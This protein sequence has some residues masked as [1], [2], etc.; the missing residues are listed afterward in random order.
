MRLARP[1]SLLWFVAVPVVT[2]SLWLR[3]P[4]IPLQTLTLLLLSFGLA[5]AGL[6]TLNDISDRS[7]DRAS[8]ESQRHMRPLAT[9]SVS[10]RGAYVQVVLLETCALIA[11]LAVSPIFLA[12]VGLG[13]LYGVGYSVRP[14]YA[15]GR[16]VVSQA[17]WIAVWPAM[18]I[19]VYIGV[20]G[21]FVAGLPYLAAT[22]LFMGVGET[23]AKDLRDIDNDSLT[24]KRTTPVA[25]GVET[26]SAVSAVALVLGSVAYVVA[27]ATAHRGAP[28]LLASITV[29]VGL[30]CGRALK[31][32]RMLR[33][34]YA[35]AD[36]RALHM[37]CI[38]VF[39]T[40]NLLFI[41]GLGAK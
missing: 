21:D 39:L 2:I 31:L 20:G 16:P 27:A 14:V 37:G 11:A 36:A 24:G 15:E 26:A 4:A 38:R 19:G 12:L 18:Y 28:A 5:D 7:T 35:K 6:T 40:A 8:V 32:T 41:T 3:G 29:V 23:L 1:Y 30:W 25:V 10:V 9:G 17:F 34:G 33:S 13:V 22:V